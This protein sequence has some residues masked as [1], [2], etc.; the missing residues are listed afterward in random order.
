MEKPNLWWE[1]IGFFPQ[2]LFTLEPTA[3]GL[4]GILCND[5]SH[6]HYLLDLNIKTLETQILLSAKVD[7]NLN[8]RILGCFSLWQRSVGFL[9]LCHSS[10]HL[11]VIRSK[12]RF[13]I[14]LNWSTF[15]QRTLIVDNILNIRSKY[16]VY[17]WREEPWLIYAE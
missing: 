7:L 1:T 16:F 5:T 14:F 17:I 13:I 8:Y 9:G 12:R 15:T 11:T 4:S 2:I 3:K 6:F 10:N